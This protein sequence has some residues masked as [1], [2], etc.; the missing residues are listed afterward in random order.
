MLVDDHKAT[1]T[2]WNKNNFSC[3]APTWILRDS[4]SVSVGWKQTSC[5]FK[6]SPNSWWA[7][8]QQEET[9]CQWE[10][11]AQVCLETSAEIWGWKTWIFSVSASKE[12]LSQSLGAELQKALKPNCLGYGEVCNYTSRCE[13][14]TEMRV[15]HDNEYV[16]EPWCQKPVSQVKLATLKKKKK[17][18]RLQLHLRPSCWSWL[19]LW[20]NVLLQSEGSEK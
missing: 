13:G 6:I 7:S 3:S 18:K 4:I 14:M 9:D 20:P 12:G 10:Q 15:V 19:R 8:K 5:T 1:K 11:R 16:L 17:K 2:D